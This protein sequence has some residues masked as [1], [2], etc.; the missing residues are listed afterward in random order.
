MKKKRTLKE[1]FL[2]W[3]DE[4]MSEGSLGLIKLLTIVTTITALIVAFVMQA[5]GILVSGEYDTFGA[6]LWA[7]FSSIINCFMPYYDDG[8]VKYRSLIAFNTIYSLF[9]TSFLIGIISTG[10][11]GKITS[12]KKGNVP[13]MEEGHIVVLGFEPGEYSLIQELVYGADKRAVCI[14]VAG[15]T[16]REEMEECIRD[17]V[18]CP[19]NVRILCRSI[20][21]FDPHTLERCS[22]STCRTVLINPTDN[23]RTIRMLL[24]VT[25]IL[26][27]VPERGISTIAVLSKDD[28]RI[29]PAMLDKYRIMLLH[30]NDTIAKIMAHSCTQPGL[31]KTLL[32]MF[33]FE[34]SEMHIVSLPGTE[35]LTFEELIC[36]VD[37]ASPLGIYKGEELHLNPDPAM[38]L[39]PGDKLLVFCEESDSAKFVDA[40]ALP[41]VESL[42]AYSGTEESGRVVIIGYSAFLSTILYELPEN[43]PAA[44][45]VNVPEQFREESLK[46]AEKRETKMSVSFFDKDMSNLNALEELAKEA[47]HIVLL[48]AYN[49][50]DDEADLQNIFMI[51]A[52]RDIRERLN[53]NFNITTEM[54][55]ENNQNLLIPAPDTEFLVSSNMSS[56]FLAQ[57]S[58]SPELLSAFDELL[59]NEGSEVYLKTAAELHCEGTRTVLELRRRLLP[60]RH[61]MIGWMDGDT[62]DC[63]FE[64]SLSDTLNLK[65]HDKLIVISED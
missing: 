59:T 41:P 52:L 54:R 47:D 46:A 21:I 15:E 51:M 28:Y 4:K 20:N 61:L 55:R 24:A 19:K 50:P 56:L 27:Q 53:L 43:V 31:S 30:T 45:L 39:E 38:V 49:K 32:E 12:L 33:H 58:E 60:L 14:V 36:R 10:I 18:K 8:D 22:I 63:T 44:T 3:L 11:Q 13:I 16:D 5:G 26:H 17:N 7:S 57:L 1:K 34:G 23:D 64:L 35:G 25:M 2:Y 48:S 9:V 62:L 37:D 6:R 40:P 42:P 65:P 29:P